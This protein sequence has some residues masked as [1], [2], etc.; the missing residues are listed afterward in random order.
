MTEAIE[1]FHFGEGAS[2][3]DYGHTNGGVAWYARD[4]AELLGYK[5]FKSFENAVNRAIQACIALKIDVLGNFTQVVREI[6]GHKVRDYK[7]SRFACYLTAMN[8][9][10]RKPQ[11]AKAQAYFA[12]M[13]ETVRLHFQ[14]AEN[15][16]RL[17][18]RDDYSEREKSLSTTAAA[19]GV[20][21]HGYFRNEGYRGLYNMP[22]SRLK[23]YKGVTQSTVLLDYMGKEEL[24][25]NLFRITQTEAKIKAD[26]IYGQQALEDTAF[27]VGR[28]V[29]NT[30]L[31][32]SGV[33]PENL[34]LVQNITE[35]RRELKK[36]QKEFAKIDKPKK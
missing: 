19:A 1:H 29:R 25:A 4:L 20:T 24:A 32:I 9:D 35:V 33:R 2:F 31:E 13:A 36:T 10:P 22:L 8:S 18:I 5:E 28:K 27:D 6:D 15:V 12:A 11:V 23:A 30:M 7:L 3:E 21:D 34:Q 14:N 26:R 16:E 17:V